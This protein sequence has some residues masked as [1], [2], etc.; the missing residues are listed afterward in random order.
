MA[1][2][3][4]DPSQDWHWQTL[5]DGAETS[6]VVLYPLIFLS[7]LL[8]SISGRKHHKEARKLEF[9]V[10][11]IAS[12][13]LLSQPLSVAWVETGKNTLKMYV[14]TLKIGGR[15]ENELLFLLVLLLDILFFLH[16]H[17]GFF[18]I[19]GSCVLQQQQLKPNLTYAQL[20]IMR[21]AVKLTS[22]TFKKEINNKKKMG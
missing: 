13:T 11:D 2:H 16:D 15:R 3:F 1:H 7:C 6:R 20:F 5:C 18:L 8:E 17:K 14:C 22:Y 19:W 9:S 10:W 4:S 21:L 12:L